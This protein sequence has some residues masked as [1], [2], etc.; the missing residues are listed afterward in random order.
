M[1][2]TQID[3]VLR[4]ENERIQID[5]TSSPSVFFNLFGND[6]QPTTKSSISIGWFEQLVSL[7]WLSIG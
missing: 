6:L 1:Y 4:K 5:C 2:S 3:F 7:K